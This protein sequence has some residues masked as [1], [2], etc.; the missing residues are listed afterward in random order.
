MATR[1]PKTDVTSSLF[2]VVRSLDDPRSSKSLRHPLI[3]VVVIVLFG[4]LCGADSWVAIEDWG[5]AKQDWLSGFLDMR[6]GVP[7][8]DTFGRIF[9]ILSPT[10]F[11]TAFS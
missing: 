5:N 9:P 4:V 7:S 8:H 2:D 1:R 6:E 3:N 10:A 11:Q